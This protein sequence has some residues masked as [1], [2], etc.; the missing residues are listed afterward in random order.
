MKHSKTYRQA[1]SNAL[2]TNKIQQGEKKKK[3]QTLSNQ[4]MTS[5]FQ[6]SS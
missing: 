1:V 6:Y 5:S 2:K 3:T 4:M